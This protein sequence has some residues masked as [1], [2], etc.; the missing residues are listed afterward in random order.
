MAFRKRPEIQ[1]FGAGGGNTRGIVGRGEAVE[2]DAAAREGAGRVLQ[3]IEAAGGLRETGEEG[4]F[5][6]GEV[7]E[8]LLEVEAGGFGG[9]STMVAVRQAV[10]VSGE[11]LV[12]RPLH[13][14]VSGEQGFAELGA[15]G[16]RGG[17]RGEF[18]EL[19][20]DGGGT[21]DAAA[22]EHGVLGGA[23]GG[24]QV[25]AAVGAE[26]LVLGGEGAGDEVGGDLIERDR[27]AAGEVGEDEVVE[28]LAVAVQEDWGGGGV[29]C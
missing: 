20:G 24:E 22:V 26:A 19:L 15:E 25:D 12:L 28:R 13:L 2:H 17:G 8:R 18:D 6:E 10:E 9:P 27:R 4:A 5:A 16:A 21:G 11:D 14:E 1:G 23:G 3:G 7:G 29:V